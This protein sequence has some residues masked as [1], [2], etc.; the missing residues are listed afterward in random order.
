MDKNFNYA[1]FEDKVS[2][3][4]KNV[5]NRKGGY[6]NPVSSTTMPSPSRLSCPS[7]YLCAY[8]YHFNEINIFNEDQ[9]QNFT[10]DAG[11][12]K[13]LSRMTVALH[14]IQLKHILRLNV[15]NVYIIQIYVFN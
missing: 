8:E 13:G 3:M 10:M 2:S 14:D 12:C 5:P 4:L 15:N 11:D 1:E 6:R 9:C 7:S